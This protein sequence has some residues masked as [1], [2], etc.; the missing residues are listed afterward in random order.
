MTTESRIAA[1]MPNARPVWMN[2]PR[3]PIE[4]ASLP[5]ILKVET[6]IAAPSRQ[7]MSVTVVEVGSP[8]EL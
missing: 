2:S 6:A 1:T 8:H 7:K 5:A 3:S 4:S